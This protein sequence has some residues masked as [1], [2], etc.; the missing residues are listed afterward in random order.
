MRV[1]QVQMLACKQTQECVSDRSERCVVAPFRSR[2]VQVLLQCQFGGSSAI[3]RCALRR[4]R[5]TVYSPERFAYDAGIGA[6]GGLC[7][8]GTSG[9]ARVSARLRYELYPPACCPLIILWA[10]K[11]D[12]GGKGE[13]SRERLWT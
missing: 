12:A 9:P 7:A 3:V 2:K 13:N 1:F 6:L 10:R 4:C 11:T 5:A 8:V